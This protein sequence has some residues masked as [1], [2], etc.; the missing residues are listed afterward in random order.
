VGAPPSG[1]FMS[2]I[3]TFQC[4]SEVGTCKRQASRSG[5]GCQAV[6]IDLD[7]PLG[8]DD[9]IV[10]AVVMLAPEAGLKGLS[11]AQDLCSYLNI[12]NG[13]IEVGPELALF[14]HRATAAPVVLASHWSAGAPLVLNSAKGFESIQSIRSG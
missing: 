10:A 7:R 12:G 13:P 1:G 8:L 2:G 3:P 5:S 6:A 14:A 4:S 11:Y 9:D